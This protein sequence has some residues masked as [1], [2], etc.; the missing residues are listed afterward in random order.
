LSNFDVLRLLD[1]DAAQGYLLDRPAPL[2]AILSQ[3]GSGN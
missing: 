3:S 2:E 1:A